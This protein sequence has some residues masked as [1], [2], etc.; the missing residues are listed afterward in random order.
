MFFFVCRLV[1]EGEQ[2]SEKSQ[3]QGHASEENFK[4][5]KYG[6]FTQETGTQASGAKFGKFTRKTHGQKLVCPNESPAKAFDRRMVLLCRDLFEL[7][8]SKVSFY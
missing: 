4:K 5:I 8:C 2:N 1:Q 3:T 6:N 7:S